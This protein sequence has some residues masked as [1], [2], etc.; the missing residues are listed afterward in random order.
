MVRNLARLLCALILP[1]VLCS[2]HDAWAGQSTDQLRDGVERVFRIL[3]DPDL[4]GEANGNERRTLIL[5]IAHEIFDFGEMAKR[6][7]GQHWRERTLVERGEFVRLFTELIKRSYIARVDLST[8]EKMVVRSETVDGDHAVVRTTLSLSR[9]REIPLDYSMHKTDDR[10][11][12]YDISVG[13]TGLVA[14]YRAQFNRIIRTASYEVLMAK[15]RSNQA[16]SSVA[17]SAGNTAQ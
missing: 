8:S 16:E 10:W 11:Q 7:L 12:V 13:G 9:G 5:R 1:T 6:S 14:N 2:A 3:R 15:L 17:P 4:K